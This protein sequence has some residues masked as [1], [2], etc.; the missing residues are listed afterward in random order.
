MRARH[1]LIAL[2]A[3][4]A[5]EVVRYLHQTGRLVSALVRPGLWLL[6]FAA[7]FENVLGVSITPP[8]DTYVPYQVYVVPG[9]IGMVLLF[10]GMQSSLSMVY[11]REMGVMRLLLTV[12]L[13]RWYLLFCKL[14]AGT[15]L[16]L[17]Q[18]YAFLVVATVVGV[19][20]PLWGML[21]ALPAMALVGLMLGALGL[22][23]SVYIRQLENFAGTMN[24]VIF[25]M[26]FLSTSLYPV[27]RLQEAGA[28]LIA[29]IVQ[30]NPFSYGIELIR[31]ALYGRLDP[32][33]AIVVGAS[34]LVFFIAAV[35]G[36]DPQRGLI[37]RTA[38]AAT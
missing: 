31:F 34:A 4:A 18:A 2:E 26:F 9:L 14:V 13:P 15:V 29:D 12:P 38:Q 23:V 33:A 19:Q 37:R 10:Q 28:T 32:L 35:H 3:V 21:S 20:L 7:G 6:V 11:E 30:V 5:R 22:L 17:L 24:F 36:Y 27:W 8:Y 1:A 16:S 25:P